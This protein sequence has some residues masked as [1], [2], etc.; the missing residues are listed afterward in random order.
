MD[1]SCSPLAKD[2]YINIVYVGERDVKS[3]IL[4]AASG[5]RSTRPVVTVM[6]QPVRSLG[7]LLIPRASWQNA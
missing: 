6:V 7:Y 3:V 2:K 4:V 1:S 5:N